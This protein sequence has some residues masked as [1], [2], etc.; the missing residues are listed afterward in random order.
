[1]ETSPLIQG[2]D[3]LKGQEIAGIN[4][5]AVPTSEKLH[6]LAEL[7]ESGKLRV[8]IQDGYSIDEVSEAMAAFQNGTR[9]KIVLNF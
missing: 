5:G 8:P 3:Q 7:V 6:Q 1:V 9:G 2:V 4:A